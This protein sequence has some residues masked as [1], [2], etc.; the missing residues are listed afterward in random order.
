MA[1]GRNEKRLF[2][3]FT[4]EHEASVL[5]RP[6]P[7]YTLSISDCRALPIRCCDL[8]CELTQQ[9]LALPLLGTLPV[10]LRS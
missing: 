6:L 7:P 8:E 1:G 9:E 2:K 4:I 3:H 5:Q 10:R